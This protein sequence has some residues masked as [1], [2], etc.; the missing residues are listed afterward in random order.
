MTKAQKDLETIIYNATNNWDEPLDEVHD[1][2]QISNAIIAAG[3]QERQPIQVTAE[4]ADRAQDAHHEYL[5]GNDDPL[6]E[7][8]KAITRQAWKVALEAALNSIDQV[9]RKGGGNG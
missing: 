8:D 3:W 6:T 4:M 9:S 7:R 2:P 5:F 1:I